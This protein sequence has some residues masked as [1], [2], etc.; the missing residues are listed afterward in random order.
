MRHDRLELFG[1]AVIDRLVIQLDEIASLSEVRMFNSRRLWWKRGFLIDL[2]NGR[3]IGV[4]VPEPFGRRWRSKLSGGTLPELPAVE[5]EKSEIVPLLIPLVLGFVASAVLAIIRRVWRA[6]NKDIPGVPPTGSPDR[7]ST[8]KILALVGGLAVLLAVAGG[9]ISYRYRIQEQRSM[10]AAQAH[11]SIEPRPPTRERQFNAGPY[12][13]EF[14]GGGRIELLAI[15]PNSSTNQP[16]WQPDGL[17]SAFGRDVQPTSQARHPAGVV[18]IFREEFPQHL[19]HWPRANGVWGNDAT[20]QNGVEGFGPSNQ[21]FSNGLLAMYFDDARSDGEETTLTVKAATA[22]WQTLST[23]TPG[24]LNSL[25]P[26]SA[27]DRWSFAATSAGD[28]KVHNPHLTENS[29]CEYRFAAVDLDE[30]E[31]L[32]TETI[33]SPSETFSS[34]EVIFNGLPRKAVRE[35][36]WEAR[37]FETVEFHHVSLNPGHRTTVAVKDFG[38]KNRSAPAKPAPSADLGSVME[39]EVRTATAPMP[40]GRIP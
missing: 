12:V 7:R 32:A 38:G 22:P 39:R 29:L 25:W 36:R 37:P 13:A 18:A 35:V 27:E 14:P 17:L 9:I 33:R 11:S 20:F 31:Y 28:L 16:W 1:I 26:R 21:P 8:G 30:K 5:I 2:K 19:D 10:V 6:A 3:R 24:L 34:Y 23:A 40:V 4:A 15:R